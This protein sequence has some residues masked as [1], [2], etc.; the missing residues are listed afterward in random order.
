L[1]KNDLE[2]L[3]IKK[4]IKGN[5]EAF[6][7]L[8]KQHEQAL[9]AHACFLS[10]NEKDAED[11]LQEALLKAFIYIK[12]F[13]GNSSFKTWLWKI[14]RNEFYNF[15]TSKKTPGNDL[16]LEDFAEIDNSNQKTPET[17]FFVEEQKKLL[18]H[19]ISKLSQK[20]QEV[21]ILVDLQEKSYEEVAEILEISIPAL[22]SRLFR[23]REKLTE[24]TLK[25][26]KL[27]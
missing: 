27:F 13:K 8:V 22:K 19:I 16:Y 26:K 15:K 11:I 3:L 9:F 12:N 5:V 21:I 6:S 20:Y 10:K 24:I 2:H 1:T 23:A 4:A 7:K 14:V 18:K 25:N 17:Q